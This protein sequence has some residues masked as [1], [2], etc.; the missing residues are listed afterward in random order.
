MHDNVRV[1]TGLAALCGIAAYY[2]IAANPASL[3]RELALHGRA[4]PR[5]VIRAAKLTGLKARLVSK[6]SIRR[7]ASVPLPAITRLQD[8]KFVVL[9]GRT[10]SG[11][12]RIVDP[13][14]RISRELPIDEIHRM[15][16]KF[17]LLVQRQ[18]GGS[19]VDPRHFGFQWFLSSI[20]RYRR[21]LLHVLVA[22]LFVQVF[23]LVTPLFFQVVVDK[24]L[25]H[26]S[27]STLLVLVGGI[28]AIGLF[29]VVLQY[30]RTYAL[31]HTSNRIDVEL[32]HR[33]FTHLLRLPISYFESRS[34]GQTIARVRELET[35][36]SFLTGQGLFSLID[37]LFTFVYIAVL[38]AYSVKLTWT[39][40]VAIP[41]YL[42]IA[43]AVR[44]TLKEKINQKFNLGAASQQFLVES[45]VGIQTIKTSAVEPIIRTQWEERLAA[46]VQS[47][48]A[49]TKLGA[50]GQNTIQ[51]VSK[52][53][54]AL[55]LLF[56]A[57]AVINEELTIGGLVAF[58]MIAGQ[59]AQPILRLSQF[60]QDFQQVQVSVE[61]LGD[62]LNASPEH[63][64][65]AFEGMTI[66]KGQVVFKH[67]TFR[68]APGEQEA[69]KDVSFTINPGEVI[70]IVGPSGSGKSTL[71]KLIQRLYV[72]SEGEVLLDG[73]NLTHIDP[74]WLRRHIGVVLQESTLFH[75]TI[76]ENIALANPAMSRSQVIAV[77]RLSG[78]DEFISKLR[79][80]YDTMIEERG[81]NL[82][83]G[84][85]Q[86]LAIARALATDPPIL[87]FDEA[88]SA[89]D[90]ESEQI[91][92]ANMR[93]IAR[94]RT[95]I[96]IAHRLVTVRH[97]DRI[98]GIVDGRLVETGTHDTLVQRPQGLYARLWA[99]Q[100]NTAKD[101]T[102]A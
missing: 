2:R 81:A 17:I 33:L 35:I 16:D 83:G 41:V 39:V 73:R 82:S 3:A 4:E 71:A 66:P 12:I 55:L 5:D 79:Q 46:Y 6:P 28:A 84:Q 77:A 27:Y 85:R 57:E 92:Q 96:I 93:H 1:D 13:I 11:L 45:V 99:L 19:G 54:S 21:P 58:N 95:V 69:L 50:G 37:L 98:F 20:W 61:R 43:F 47:A 52:L 87:V 29:D 91:I 40:L 9:G 72:P 68:Y 70:G 65:A 75:R 48:F 15:M 26:K 74:V 63:A 42:L 44:P 51:Y 32:S 34:A 36:R 100:N 7:I 88:T 102:V 62:I 30:L 101:Q 67:V 18:V 38:E 97:C 31:A 60:W 25:P 53:S 56:G 78:A 59:V 14:T 89:L 80:G 24:V 23:A 94:G 10:P 76:H 49:A 90:Y 8:G 86:R 22:S 64:P